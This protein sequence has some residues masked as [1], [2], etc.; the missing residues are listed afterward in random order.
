L[1]KTFNALEETLKKSK[2]NLKNMVF[3]EAISKTMKKTPDQEGQCYYVSSPSAMTE[4]SIAI[5]KFL[6]HEF[7]Y[8]IFD[9]L[10]S[11][12]VYEKNARRKI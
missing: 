3:I 9:S 5:E 10:N 1:N 2:A 6:R 8:L 7:D 4:L 11:L 12:L